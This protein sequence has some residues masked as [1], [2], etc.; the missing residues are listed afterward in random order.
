MGKRC[1]SRRRRQQCTIVAFYAP[2]PPLSFVWHYFFTTRIDVAQTIPPFSYSIHSV[3]Q[4]ASESS[5]HTVWS[6][7]LSSRFLVLLFV[8]YY[9]WWFILLF[10]YLCVFSARP[11]ANVAPSST[12]ILLPR[13]PECMCIMWAIYLM[14]IKEAALCSRRGCFS[15]ERVSCWLWLH[16]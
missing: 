6:A 8:C 9:F 4:L 13:L 16:V 2:P 15:M 12:S 11:N 3:A 1:E 10:T 5:R 7:F 14:W